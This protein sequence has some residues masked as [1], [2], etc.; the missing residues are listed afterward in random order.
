VTGPND[1]GGKPRYNVR[2]HVPEGPRQLGGFSTATGA[3]PEDIELRE[4]EADAPAEDPSTHLI[5]EQSTALRDIS[6]LAVN[7]GANETR[8]VYY[9]VVEALSLTEK[10]A[11]A[12]AR[13]H[14]RGQLRR[15]VEVLLT[16]YGAPRP[17]HWGA[18]RGDVIEWLNHAL[19][20]DRE[21]RREATA[22]AGMLTELG[23]SPAHTVIQMAEF[24]IAK[25]RAN[26]TKAAEDAASATIEQSKKRIDALETDKTTLLAQVGEAV[27]APD[28]IRE[29]SLEAMSL[30]AK[31]IPGVQGFT[32]P[33]KLREVLAYLNDRI[34]SL[35]LAVA[36]A[37]PVT[38]VAGPDR[39]RAV[40][41]R[42]VDGVP[43]ELI[44][45]LGGWF[46]RALA[47]ANLA[48]IVY[49]W[50]GIDPVAEPVEPTV[51]P[52]EPPTLDDVKAAWSELG[53]Y[54]SSML[55]EFRKN[56]GGKP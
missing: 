18:E 36:S 35:E 27:A 32:L 15:E 11:A 43:V 17:T 22:L 53:T 1:V 8:T 25:T 10:Q 30:L 50:D 48:V 3:H 6:R 16:N 2:Y 39:V 20:A 29:H 5:D 33:Q 55:D 19:C 26:A 45:D 23:A 49:N 9:Q 47:N 13:E 12:S 51:K 24:V 7:N 38:V 46:L 56:L 4:I 41:E 14:A 40:I 28:K 42:A 37:H 44:E 52:A 31:V 21:G 34:S 54:F